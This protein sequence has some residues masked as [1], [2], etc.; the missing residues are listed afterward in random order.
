MIEVGL[1]VVKVK[2][3]LTKRM[4]SPKFGACMKEG[5]RKE[6]QRKCDS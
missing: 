3:W 2:Y 4:L 6:S 1:L 5:L